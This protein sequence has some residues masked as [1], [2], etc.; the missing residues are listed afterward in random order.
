MTMPDN[1]VLSI[2]VAQIETR[3]GDLEANKRTHLDVIGAA[4][5]AGAQVLVC[6]E[7]SLAGH[8]GGRE[9]PR[10]ALTAASPMLAELA[11][12]SD[13]MLTVVGA[14]EEAPGALFYNT[15]FGLGGGR[16]LFRHR[17]VNL[18]TYGRL[19]DG[20]HFAAGAE[21]R[22][23]EVAAPWRAAVLICADLW[24]PPLVHLAALSGATVLLAPISSGRE[25][26][27]DGF[28]NPEGWAINARFHAM[29]YGLPLAL[30]N[31]V[32]TE[33]DLTFWGG[34][35]ILDPFG[36]ELARAG[37][38]ETLITA[39][40]PYENLRQARFLLPTVRDGAAPL[41]AC[42]F[43]RVAGAASAGHA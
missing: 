40:V 31:R 18:A 36:K 23:H 32:G 41:L 22:T 2:A 35:R 33:G 1:A 13:D 42:E 20:K 16:V 43:A 39:A 29:T 27:G 30:A 19:D 6:P 10:L 37:E 24:N 12:A 9:A 4:R 38:E 34:S 15:A 8:A 28:D 7:L 14:V 3:L 25:A 11:A 26:V 5:A 21:I 17:K